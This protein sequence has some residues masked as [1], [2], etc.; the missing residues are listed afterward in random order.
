M[1]RPLHPNAARVADTL[2]AR[3]HHGLITTQSTPVRTAEQAAAAVR[4]DVG[5]IVES[6]VLL[7]D[8]EPILVLVSGAHR[9]SLE[10]A[11]ARL[12]GTLTPAPDDLIAEVTGQQPGGVAPLGHPTNLPTYVDCALAGYPELWASGG[13]LDTLFRTSYTELL[14]ITAGVDLEV[15]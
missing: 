14:R 9:V 5:A 2:I 11:G 4:V 13:S 8:E 12:A 1:P 3:G 10:R 6:L 7:L 15:D